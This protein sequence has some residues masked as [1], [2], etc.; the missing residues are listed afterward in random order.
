MTLILNLDLDVVK[1]YQYSPDEAPSLSSSKV[2]SGKERQTRLKLLPFR[3]REWYL[4]YFISV[5][6]LI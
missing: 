6:Q 4:R 2:I 5:E 1:V 3:I